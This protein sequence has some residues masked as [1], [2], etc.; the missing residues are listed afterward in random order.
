MWREHGLQ[1]WRTETFKFTT[2][3]DL[4]AKVRDVVGLYLNP[5]DKAVVLSVDEKSQIQALDRTAPILPI[6]PGLLEKATHDYVRHGGTL[7]ASL[8]DVLSDNGKQFTGRFGKPRPAEVLFE[9][10]CRENGITQRLTK[11]RSPTTT[12]KIERLH[13]NRMALEQILTQLLGRRVWLAARTGQRGKRN[14]VE[15]T[16]RSGRA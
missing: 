11:P 5:P 6:W 12:G 15:Q 9:R 8:A 14:V 7:F 16:M 3:P 10:I 1:P 13:Q 4:E 2:D